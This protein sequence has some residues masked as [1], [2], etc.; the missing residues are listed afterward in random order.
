[1]NDDFFIQLYVRQET[2]FTGRLETADDIQHGLS[3]IIDDLHE[4]AM[5]ENKDTCLALAGTWDLIRN[6][7]ARNIATDEREKKA[8]LENK[9]ARSH[10][11]QLKN[12]IF[13]ED[14][15]E[16]KH[17][18]LIMAMQWLKYTCQGLDIAWKHQWS[19][20]CKE[21]QKESEIRTLKSQIEELKVRIEDDKHLEKSQYALLDH[22]QWLLGYPQNM[23]FYL[24]KTERISELLSDIK[25]LEFFLRNN[26]MRIFYFPDSEHNDFIQIP[27][28]TVSA[29]ITTRPLIVRNDL[30]VLKGCIFIPDKD[31]CLSPFKTNDRTT[32]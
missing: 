31:K 4:C 25:Q 21:R 29:P 26:G 15:N 14:K 5:S 32:G 27:E 23:E 24:E 6:R 18:D 17:H 20:I 13:G 22:I 28:E 30:V 8:S 16:K 7:L 12:C 9:K 2:E 19:N 11:S 1:M 3:Q 10:V